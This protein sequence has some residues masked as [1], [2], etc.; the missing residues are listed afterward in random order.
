MKL[1]KIFFKD[2]CKMFL[3]TFIL[4]ILQAVGTLMIPYYVAEII[5]EGILT[6]DQGAIW[7]N[8][9]LM[10]GVA[11]LTGIV[12]IIASYYSAVLAGRFGYFFT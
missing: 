2:Y 12:S 8:G 10:L 3:A 11:V 6:Q 9:G 4:M 1:F 7:R 5:D